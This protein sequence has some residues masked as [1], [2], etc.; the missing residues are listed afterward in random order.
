[1]IASQSVNSQT[2]ICFFKVAVTA[3]LLKILDKVE[4]PELSRTLTEQDARY[5]L[6]FGSIYVNGLRQS[7]DL[8]L[9]TND[10]IRLHT[11]PKRF[12]SVRPLSKQILVDHE[13]FLVVNKP[14]GLPVHPTVDNAR[15]NVKSILESELGQ[16]LYT[17]HRLDVPTEGL[18]LLAKTKSAQALLNKIFAKKRVQKC[19]SAWTER[20]LPLGRHKHF[21]NPTLK[22]P[23]EISTEFS[24]GWWECILDIHSVEETALGFHHKVELITGK[25]HQIRAQFQ[26]LGA[27]ILGDSMYG[28]SLSWPDRR[29]LTR[30]E[31]KALG[32]SC[33][34]LSFQ[35]RTELCAFRRDSAAIENSVRT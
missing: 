27:P 1:M 4:L 25:T 15:E 33:D 21:I 20:A 29:P 17:T 19:Y 32:L 16:T 31:T 10:V 7:Q 34:S 35:F 18:L 14:A 3:N 13:E 23:R 8:I 22:A 12:S 24:P 28:S 30:G 5:W 26:A 9:K 2:G 11:N 6:D